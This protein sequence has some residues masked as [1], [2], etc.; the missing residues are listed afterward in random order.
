M[1]E[2]FSRLNKFIEDRLKIHRYSL[3][4]V[5]LFAFLIF[6]SMFLAL[7]VDIVHS[8][9]EV[10][11]D[12]ELAAERAAKFRTT[13][14][15]NVILSL[16]QADVA[17]AGLVETKGP[18]ALKPFMGTFIVCARG[19]GFQMGNVEGKLIEEALKGSSGKRFYFHLFPREWLGVVVIDLKGS[20]YVFCH[21]VP[22]IESILSKKLGA[23]AKYGAEFRFGER[24]KVSEGDIFVVYENDY[25]NASMYVLVPFR[26][27]LGTLIA[28]RVFLYMRLYFVFLLFLSVSYLLWAKLINYPINRLRTAVEELERGNYRVDFSDMV[29]AKDEFGSIARLL[30]RFSEETQRRFEK[31]ELILDTALSSVRSPEDVHSFIKNTLHRINNI[32]GARKSLF[33]V[34]ERETGKFP[35]LVHSDGMSEQEL[36]LFLEVYREKSRSNSSFYEEPVCIKDRRS[37]GCLNVS[38]FNIDETTCGGVV[39]EMD[40]DIDSVDEGYLKVVCQHLFG[41]IRLTHM[42]TTDPLTGIPNRRVME[43]DI[44]RYSRLARRYK[45]P[46]SL[47][48]IDIDNFKGVNDTYGHAT[49]DEVLKKVARLIRESIR[50]TDTVYRYGG[51]EFA[52]LC[53]ETD[54]SGAYELAERIREKVRETRLFID[55]DRAIYITISLG[56]A[57]FPDDTEDPAELLAIADISL[58]RA[59]SEGKDRTATLTGSTDKELFIE[60]FRK[61]KE[62]RAYLRKGATVHHLQPI[63]DLQRDRVFGY[64]LLFRVVDGDRTY[65]MGEFLRYVEDLGLIEDIDRLTVKR[66]SRLIRDESL[67]PYCFFINISPRSLDRGKVISDLGLIP[68]HQRSRI[69]IEITERE[70]FMN[71][72]EALKHIERLKNMGFRVVLDDFGSGFSS[73]SQLRHFVK[74]LDL[75]KVDGSFIRNIH[76]DP[77]NR[78]IVESM[79]TM[80]DKFSIDLVAEFIEKEEELRT[81]RRV[82]I[83]FGQGFY[84]G[85]ENIRAIT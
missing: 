68:K 9:S 63:Y 39:F 24:P 58:Y 65:T 61:E 69:Y 85:K 8:I 4:V 3:K 59:K 32:F 70:T 34:E 78:A 35:Y 33:I 26:N 10:R 28:D 7:V 25:S 82:G 53:P 60:K 22:Y 71:T 74:L 38:L 73:M 43:H 80:A 31:L 72:D 29:S 76:R 47:V 51:E 36:D 23:I 18:E 1:V 67:L 37:G 11:S 20:P 5:L 12:I 46:L 40:C 52:V 54:K 45:K 62:L 2:L 13:A 41:T 75:I 77:Y 64:E 48:M 81:V 17:L 15:R 79:K 44:D 6:V 55:G 50:E 16:F 66:L 21:K 49:G 27:I 84:F 57:S 83:R 42:A 19:K 14:I 30:K 56:V